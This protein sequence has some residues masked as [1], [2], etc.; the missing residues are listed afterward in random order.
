MKNLFKA[1]LVLLSVTLGLSA[2]GNSP[3]TVSLE[4]TDASATFASAG[5][6]LAGFQ[7]GKGMKGGD[8][9]GKG[10]FGQFPGIELTAEQ[11]TA[12]EALRPAP[13]QKDPATMKT[14]MEAAQ[15]A[16]KDAFLADSINKDDLKAKLASF[17]PP[18][19][20]F[21]KQADIMVKSYNILTAE[22]KATLETKE[23]EM[24]AKA[25]EMKAQIDA[26]IASGQV[27][28]PFD[29]TNKT[30]P[31]FDKLGTDLGL[32]AEQK[33]ALQAAFAPPA[34]ASA[35]KAARHEQM[36]ANRDAINAAVKAGDVTKLT[37]L[38]SANKPVDHLDRHVDT[39]VK[40]HGILNAEQRAKIADKLPMLGFGGGK[41]GHGGPGGKGGHGVGFGRGGNVPPAATTQAQPA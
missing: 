29:K 37:E 16:V 35:D 9:K 17:T 13:E 12:L 34:D 30:N 20:D 39:I 23:K 41:G 38:L 3:S 26:K 19:P 18:A 24:Q 40:V 21:A 33:T 31:M 32:T 4:S 8:H 2:C 25:E 27:K 22:Q 1:S 6:N 10:G 36:K 11:K 14:Q 28:A 15:K 7:G 5:R